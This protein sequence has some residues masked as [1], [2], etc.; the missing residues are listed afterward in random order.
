MCLI[1]NIF[2]LL[3]TTLSTQPLNIHRQVKYSKMYSSGNAV[4]CFYADWLVF[5]VTARISRVTSVGKWQSNKGYETNQSTYDLVIICNRKQ[6]HYSDRRICEMMTLNEIRYNPAA[7][8]FLLV[9]GLAL[10]SP[11]TH[12]MLLRIEST[13]IYTHHKQ[14]TVVYYYIE[15]ERQKWRTVFNLVSPK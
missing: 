12:S 7:S 14:A 9:V 13:G 5:P 3:V 8:T 11:H 1:S 10:K 15:R 4:Q 6:G 2:I